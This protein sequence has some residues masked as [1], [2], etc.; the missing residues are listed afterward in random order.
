MAVVVENFVP[1]PLSHFDKMVLDNIAPFHLVTIVACCCVAIG[2][3]L[4]GL[5][6]LGLYFHLVQSQVSL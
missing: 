6:P 4:G 3:H 1:I 5:Q 2:N